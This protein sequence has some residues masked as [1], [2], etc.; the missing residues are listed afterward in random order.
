MSGEYIGE[1]I[2]V[3]LAGHREDSP[4]AALLTPRWVQV[5][6]RMM[7]II[8]TYVKCIKI[9]HIAKTKVTICTVNYALLIYEINISIC[10]GMTRQTAPEPRA[11]PEPCPRS[12][13]GRA[14]E[15]PPPGPTCTWICDL[16]VDG[17]GSLTSRNTCNVHR[18]M[19]IEFL[20][21][22]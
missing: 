4:W 5:I 12:L 11:G 16:V 2:Q 9:V 22:T 10:A 1:P 21:L 19:C 6:S 15:Q 18:G 3:I 14:H 8:W 13:S 17:L 20:A 7:I